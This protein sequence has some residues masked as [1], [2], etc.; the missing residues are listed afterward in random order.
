MQICVSGGY[1]SMLD[2]AVLRLLHLAD[3]HIQPPIPPSNRT[4]CSMSQDSSCGIS[5]WEYCIKLG[6]LMLLET[7]LDS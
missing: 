2:P 7:R 5:L 1:V 3:L 6:V 4:T